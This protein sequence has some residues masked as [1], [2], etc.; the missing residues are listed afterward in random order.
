MRK[1]LLSGIAA[2]AMSTAVASAQ[3]AGGL[4]LSDQ[5]MNSPDA[6]G[7]VLDHVMG[8]LQQHQQLR[9]VMAGNGGGGNGSAALT[10]ANRPDP[11]T[12]R[13]NTMNVAQQLMQRRMAE[14]LARQEAQMQQDALMNAPPP[15]VVNAYDSPVAIGSN[16][17]VN[18]TVAS[19][20]SIGGNAQASAQ[21]NGGSTSQSATSNAVSVGGTAR[22][23]AINS[24]V[25]GQGNQ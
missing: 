17:V 18:Q 12:A 14:R 5:A 9:S 4:R 15:V 10:V 1:L 21:S 24:S 25:V 19:S 22:A 11:A 8:R 7:R 20:T 13:Q 3:E 16:N 2:L 6:Q 23:T